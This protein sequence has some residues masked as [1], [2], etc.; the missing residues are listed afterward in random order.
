MSVRASHLIINDVD[1]EIW[2]TV[3]RNG[4]GA[5]ATASTVA[6]MTDTSKVY[7]Y[8]GSETGYTAGNWYYYNGSAWVS[9]GIYNSTAFETDE[10]L[11]KQL[12]M[13]LTHWRMLL[14]PKP[15]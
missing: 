9:G 13:P 5:P 11:P 1:Y 10:T 12:A 3:A 6:G 4:I 15:K 14:P 2:D 8:T 7:V